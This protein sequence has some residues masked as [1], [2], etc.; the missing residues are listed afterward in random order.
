[1]MVYY[2]TM[3]ALFACTLNRT[4]TALARTISTC[5]INAGGNAT[6]Q[7]L[8]GIMYAQGSGGRNQSDAQAVSSFSDMHLLVVVY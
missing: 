1:M 3:N 7:L 2:Q 4:P 8:L 5:K 6:A